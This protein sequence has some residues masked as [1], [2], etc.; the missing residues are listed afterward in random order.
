LEGLRVAYG[1]GDEVKAFTDSQLH[2]FLE[3]AAAVPLYYPLLFAMSKTGLRLGEAV[4]LRWDDVDLVARE[5]TVKRTFSMGALGS[6][7]SGKTRRVDVSKALAEL[8]EQLDVERKAEALEAGRDPE[9]L[10]FP[11]RTTST[12]TSRG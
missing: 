10:V 12:S 5:I 4:A 6:P 9:E 3:A 8:L 7:K 1:V 11:G 2:A